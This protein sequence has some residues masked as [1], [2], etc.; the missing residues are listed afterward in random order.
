MG[1]ADTNAEARE[2]LIHPPYWLVHGLPW[3]TDDPNTTMAEAALALAPRLV[4]DHEVSKNAYSII[5]LTELYAKDH[6]KQRVV[7]LSDVTRWLDSKGSSWPAVGVDIESGLYEFPE[8]PIL[9]LFMTINRR[10]YNHIINAT[11]KA[12]TVHYTD[13]T[14]EQLTN[15]ERQKVR[16]DLEGV[17]VN[18]WEN[19]IQEMFARGLLTITSADTPGT[20]DY[21]EVVRCDFCSRDYTASSESGGFISDGRSWA[22]CPQCVKVGKAKLSSSDIPCPPNM[23]FADFIRE[24]R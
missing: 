6:P 10:A 15:D 4:A 2:L 17:L 18:D 12:F 11:R 5:G 21:L 22:G 13:G 16:Q 9:N 19:Y 20:D 14:S 1:A 8:A 24:Y 7:F 23:S 3:P